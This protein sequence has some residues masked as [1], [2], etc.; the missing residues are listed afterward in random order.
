MSN[1]L[2]N[3]SLQAFYDLPTAGSKYTNEQRVNAAYLYLIHGNLNKLSKY[4]QIP[5]R[6]LFDWTKSDW[7]PQLIN[8]LRLEKKDEIDSALTRVTDKAIR[9]LEDKLDEPDDISVVE[10]SKV[11]G[12]MFDKQRLIRNEPT[13]ISSNS[14]TSDQLKQLKDQFEKLAGKTIDGERVD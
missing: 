9:A 1:Q 11:Y 14:V 10:L 8:R 12:I 4:T 7:W 6:T 3:L 5:Q 2:D 13:S